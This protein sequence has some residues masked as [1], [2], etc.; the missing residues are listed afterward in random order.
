MTDLFAAPT[1]SADQVCHELLLSAGR[2]AARRAAVA[3]AGLAGRREPGRAERHPAARAAAAP[4]RAHR[5][6]VRAAG[7]G[8]RRVGGVAPAGRR[9][10]AGRRPGRAGHRL[11]GGPGRGRPGRAQRAGR[12]A[13]PPRLPGAVPGP[14]RRGG[15]A[16]ARA[17]RPDQRVVVVRGGDRPWLL[18][19]TLQRVLRAHGDRTP[20]VE[21]LPAHGE[22]TGL[23]PGRHHHVDAAVV[24]SIGGSG[25]SLIGRT[26]GGRMD[27]TSAETT[28]DLLLDLAGR[29]DDD[30][31][32]WARELVAVGETQHAVELLGATLVADRAEL[33]E[34]TRAALVGAARAVR[35]ELDADAAL[36][37]ARPGGGDTA[38]RFDAGPAPAVVA[39]VRGAAGPAAG[40][41]PG[42]AG[43]PAD[44]GRLGARSAAAPGRAGRGRARRPQPGRAGL[45]ARRRAGPGRR[46][47]LGRGDLRR[48]SGCRPITSRRCAVRSRCAGAGRAT[49]GPNRCRRTSDRRPS[50]RHPGSG[51]PRTRPLGR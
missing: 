21:V 39:A 38:H 19:G 32:A 8:G 26:E 13:R 37:A 36:P 51:R 10:A 7:R 17:P 43:P 40:R 27:E 5:A 46:A 35:T 16:G 23:P 20:C 6:R 50:R 41:L 29:V 14:P 47:R 49:T 25:R 4:G 30:L 22:L 48:A 11:P 12:G 33:P 44:P 28:H 2:P 18:T 31:L 42:V 34:S 24:R 1:R 15:A 45:P 3:A 9:R